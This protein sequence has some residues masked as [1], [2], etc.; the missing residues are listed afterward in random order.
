M[1]PRRGAYYFADAP[2]EG[3]GGGGG[4]EPPKVEGQPPAKEVP[5]A[6]P[7]PSDKPIPDIDPHMKL[8][9]ADGKGGMVTMSLGEMADEALAAKGLRD[10]NA[11]YDKA[12]EQNDPEAL[13]TLI[14]KFTPAP[15]EGK[16]QVPPEMEAVVGVIEEL[17]GQVT[18]LQGQIAEATPVTQAITR[19]TEINSLGQEIKNQGEKYPT[20]AKV[21]EAPAAVHQQLKQFEVQLKATKNITLR[22]HPQLYMQARDR[23]FGQMEERMKVLQTQLGGA[24]P[25]A[26]TPGARSVNDQN[27]TGA[28]R[29]TE[30]YRPPRIDPLAVDQVPM[31]PP[32]NAPLPTAPVTV[33]PS[34]TLGTTV[35]QEGGPLTTNTLADRMRNRLTELGGGQT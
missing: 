16:L 28:D 12:F 32:V 1:W 5:V 30:T 18:A 25:K 15:G 6:T 7:P 4:A 33:P 13:K 9:V 23:I 10:K 14:D 26:P 34:G 8:Q 31:A 27:L 17:K 20:L 24:P 29:A 21:S 11:I 35:P 19:M 22:E 2:P 3:G